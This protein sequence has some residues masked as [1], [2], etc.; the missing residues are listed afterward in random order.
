[1]LQVPIY[2]TVVKPQYIPTTLYETIFKTNL[3]T[4]VATEYLPRYVTETKYVQKFITKTVHNTEYETV[5]DSVYITETK[6]KPQYI[7]ETK[8]I[9]NYETRY[10]PKYITETK[11]DPIYK[12]KVVYRT[13]VL[14]QTKYPDHHALHHP[15]VEKPSIHQATHEVIPLNPIE[16]SFEHPVPDSFI[17]KPVPESFSYK[18]SGEGF[19]PKSVHAAAFGHK[20]TPTAFGKHIPQIKPLKPEPLPIGDSDSAEF[21]PAFRKPGFGSIGG[22][23]H[24][25]SHPLAQKQKPLFDPNGQKHQTLQI[26][27][28]PHH[29]VHVNPAE[30]NIPAPVFDPATGR[31]KDTTIVIDGGIEIDGVIQPDDGSLDG[32]PTGKPETIIEF[33]GHIPG[34]SLGGAGLGAASVGGT[35]LGSSVSPKKTP[36]LPSGKGHHSD[37]TIQKSKPVRGFG[38]VSSSSPLD[39]FGGFDGSPFSSDFSLG[40]KL[41]DALGIGR[42][43]LGAAFESPRSRGGRPG[44]FRSGRSDGSKSAS[45][46][47][48]TKASFESRKLPQRQ[49]SEG[50]RI[51]T[52]LLSR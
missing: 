45:N 50:V 14:H 7:T 17:F 2:S 51:H 42:S 43:K 33:H 39:S 19:D 48:P 32:L 47:E 34:T 4:K 46:K 9:T 37:V 40:F 11:V 8:Y 21:Q 5:V 18:P 35:S 28:N 38:S 10:Q 22:L 23:T 49:K 25:F 26:S 30:D 20:L 16:E 12:T 27:G 6:V 31:F 44:G 3:Q 41:E 13:E 29:N 24:T 36:S 1:M 15:V 52:G